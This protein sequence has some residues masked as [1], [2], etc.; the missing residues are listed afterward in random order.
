MLSVILLAFGPFEATPRGGAR[1]AIA[2]SL[3]SLVDACVQGLIADA[4]L[5][6]PQGALLAAIADEAGATHIDAATAGEGLPRGLAA[7]RYPDVFLLAAG[8]AIER[9]FVDEVVDALSFGDRARALVLRA[10][11]DSLLTRL[12]PGLA[13]PV[14]LIGKR[15]A[16]L[17]AGATDIGAL[18][19]RL[20]GVDLATRARRA[21]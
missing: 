11:P 6:G 13:R 12:A 3:S 1:E 8:H 9:G 20:R 18:G 4:A 17:A 15:D 5:V 14:G 16:I 10:A 19:K 21:L 2:R 7:A